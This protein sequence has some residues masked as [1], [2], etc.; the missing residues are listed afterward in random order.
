MTGKHPAIWSSDF[1]FTGGEDKDSI[2]H[3]DLMIEQAKKQFAAG[4]LVSLSWHAVR[5]VDDEPAPPIVGFQNSVRGKLTDEQWA[6]LI[7]LNTPLHNRWTRYVDTVADYLGKL[8]DAHVPVLWRPL[9]ECNG[10]FFWWGGRP[11]PNGTQQLYREM[12]DR[13]THV[14]HLNNL[15]WIW[16]QNVPGGRF[17]DYFP[18]QQYVD[19]LACDNYGKLRDGYYYSMLKLANGKPIALGE[20]GHPPS[21]EVLRAQPRW[22]W[23]VIWAGMVDST[24][25]MIYDAPYTIDRGDPR[26]IQ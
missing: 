26:L 5:P 13:M 24:T 11:G 15:I 22:V 14:H 8:Q 21:P 9:H 23:F 18:G 12:F 6:Q 17:A 3:R 1:G 19:V 7:T 25:R 16:D 4:A 20:L 2:A 10:S